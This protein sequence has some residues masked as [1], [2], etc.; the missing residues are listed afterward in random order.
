MDFQWFSMDSQWSC[1]CFFEV[2]GSAWGAPVPKRAQ[3]ASEASARSDS[4]HAVL[5]S[6]V[7]SGIP[8]KQILEF[9]KNNGKQ[10]AFKYKF[11]QGSPWDCSPWMSPLNPLLRP[12]QLKRCVS[13]ALPVLR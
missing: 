10:L 7:V 8:S 5:S 13:N 4:M 6:L 12:L 11:W 1:Y 9:R 3:R 2:F